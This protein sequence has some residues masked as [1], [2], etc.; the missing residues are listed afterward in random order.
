[1]S[2]VS[3]MIVDEVYNPN[4]DVTATRNQDLQ[5]QQQSRPILVPA[6]QNQYPPGDFVDDGM[7]RRGSKR[8][9]CQQ[10]VSRRVDQ[11]MLRKGV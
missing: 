9:G 8:R 3:T 7:W 6:G 1:M 10:G 5:T 2:N 4:C 11:C